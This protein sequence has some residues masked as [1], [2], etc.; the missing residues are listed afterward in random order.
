MRTLSLIENSSSESSFTNRETSDT[1]AAKHAC[2]RLQTRAAALING[3]ASHTVEF[4]EIYRAAFYHPGSGYEGKFSLPYCVAVGLID[5]RVRLDAFDDA[6]LRDPEVRELMTKAEL[7]VDQQCQRVFPQ[8]RSA[9]V[10]IRTND[11]REFA[12]HAKTRK[13]DPD[14]TLSDAEIVDKYRELAIPVRGQGL[15]EMLLDALWRVD[16]LDRVDELP[17]AR[18]RVL[19]AAGD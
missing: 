15:A 11:G 1:T 18:A 2:Y 17:L 9:R 3:A 14:A 4:D 16:V 10:T 5:A 12:H 6:H 13:G 7:S 19:S 8:H